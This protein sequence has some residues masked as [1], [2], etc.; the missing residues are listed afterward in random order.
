MEISDKLM[1]ETDLKIQLDSGYVR[2]KPREN[3]P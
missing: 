2:S 3:D 1:L